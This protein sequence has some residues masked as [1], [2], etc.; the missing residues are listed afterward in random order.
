MKWPWQAPSV[1]ASVLGSRM[2]RRSFWSLLLV[3]CVVMVAQAL[4]V[5]SQEREQR[6]RAVNDTAQLLMPNVASAAWQV[7]E[8]TMT[9]LLDS[10]VA[11][12]GVVAARFGDDQLSIARHSVRWSG[13]ENGWQDCER[14][15][16]RDLTGFALGAER[17]PA[18]LLEICFVQPGGLGQPLRNAMWAAS[19][20][21][22]LLVLASL[23]PALLVRRMVIQPI[24]ELTEAIR[25]SNLLNFHPARPP[26]DQGD[27]VD[28][29]IDELKGRTRSLLR[30]QGMANLAFLALSDGMAVVDLRSVIMRCNAA[31]PAVLGLDAGVVLVG[32]SLGDFLPPDLFDPPDGTREFEGVAGRVLE[33]SASALDI[34]GEE[35]YRVVQI[36]DLTQ[37]KRD[38]AEHRQVAKMNALG[39]LSGGVAHD[40]N[41]LLMA[42]GGSAELISLD[43]TL[44]PEGQRLL[45]TIRV[46]ARRGAT[47]TA[48]LLTFARKQ[49]MKSSSVDVRE[50]VAEVVALSRRTLGS[51][52]TVE[53]WIEGHPRVHADQTFLETALINLLVNARDA[54]PQGGAIRLEVQTVERAGQAFVRL[55]VINQGPDIPPEVLARMGE[56]F[57][58]TKTPGKGTGLGLSMVLGFAEQSG[59]RVEMASAQGLTRMAILLPLEP[60]PCEVAAA[61]LPVPVPAKPRPPPSLQLLLVDD[62]VSVRDTLAGLLGS[63]GHR[64]TV[65]ASPQEVEALLAGHGSGWDLVLCDLVLAQ[66]SGIDVHQMLR[67]RGIATPLVFIS[68]NVPSSMQSRIE[69]LDHRAVLY[70]PVS[71]EQLQKTIQSVC[72]AGGAAP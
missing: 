58:T 66:G 51:G 45:E 55:S 20:L 29:L 11:M 38:E 37:K 25:H 7:S 9:T 19:P 72:S 24:K 36:R 48:Q 13:S 49:P 3:G 71:R 42:I 23:Y 39:T 67:A 46:A 61:V 12:D 22:L 43:E 53:V 21:L 18:G 15:I 10:L 59:G 16:R 26:G 64:V 1:G 17:L 8:T 41:N 62:D 6:F 32:R 34:G 27:E 69:L 30:E 60:E 28:G 65:A 40:F 35:S 4:V 57:F 68:G 54:Q 63:L 47:L 56:P 44:T 5:L 70:K 52:H 2:L 50:V 14:V 31:L 33:V